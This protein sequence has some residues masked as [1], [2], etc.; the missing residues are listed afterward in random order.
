M[1]YLC[2]K[3]IS[4]KIINPHWNAATRLSK[5][6]TIAIVSKSIATG[7]LNKYNGTEISLITNLEAI[8]ITTSFPNKIH[9]CN[10]YIPNSFSLKIEDLENLLEQVPSSLV[11]V[12]DFNSHYALWGS[13]KTNSRGQKVIKEICMKTLN[14]VKMIRNNNWRSN[15]EILLETYRAI[16]WPKIDYG[17]T[18]YNSAKPHLLKKNRL[19]TT[20]GIKNRYRCLL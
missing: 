13:S 8:E 9:V 6:E 14:I 20:W 18:I 5:I 15:Q 3:Q 19:N 11:L 4:N 7:I 12:G 10:I 1:L 16:I 2:K 17:S